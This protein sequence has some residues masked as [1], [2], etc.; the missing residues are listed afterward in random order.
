MDHAPAVQGGVPRDGGDPS[1]AGLAS[2]EG[3]VE[4]AWDEG[5]ERTVTAGVVFEDA[6][7]ED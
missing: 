2:E 5:P 4:R 6:A 7:G 1:R 3:S